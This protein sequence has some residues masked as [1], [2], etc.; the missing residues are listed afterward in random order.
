MHPSDVFELGLHEPD[1][2]GSAVEDVEVELALVLL[3]EVELEVEAEPGTH[4][5]SVVPGS[6]TSALIVPRKAGETGYVQNM[7]WYWQ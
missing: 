1:E 3:G 2:D 5:E 7:D 4:C 6:E